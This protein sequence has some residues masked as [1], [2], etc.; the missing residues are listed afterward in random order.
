MQNREIAGKIL[1]RVRLFD[2]L[3][4]NQLSKVVDMLEPVKAKKDNAILTEGEEGF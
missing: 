1:K 2:G 3:S 4:E